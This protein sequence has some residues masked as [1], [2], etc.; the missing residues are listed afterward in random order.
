MLNLCLKLLNFSEK[1]L[2]LSQQML[3][4]ISFQKFLRFPYKTV[5]E[6]GEISME[7]SRKLG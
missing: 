2:N 7:I 1:M 4:F 3:N 5:F 6:G